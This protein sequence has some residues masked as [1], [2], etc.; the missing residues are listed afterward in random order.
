MKRKSHNT[1]ALRRVAPRA[2]WRGLWRISRVPLAVCTLAF[3]VYSRSFLNGFVRDDHLQ[4]VSNPQVQSWDRLPEILTSH[5][6][7]HAGTR[8]VLFYRPLFSLWMLIIHTLGGLS[9]WFWHLSSAALHVACT[10]L[11]YRLAKQLIGSNLGSVAAAA[12]FAVHPIHVDAVG[13]VS[14]SNELLFTL[15]MLAALLVLMAPRAK[16]AGWPV[17]VSALL[18]FAGLFAKET[19]VAMIVLLVVAAR[20]RLKDRHREIELWAMAVGPYLLAAGTWL[21]IR[22]LVL[23]GAGIEN[24]EHT[25]REVCFSAPSILLFYL[26]KLAVPLKLSGGYVNPIYASP[27]SQFLLPLAVG[28]VILLLATWL[29]VRHNWLIGFSAALILLP[30][31]PALV[32]I[33]LYPQGDMT[34]DRYLYLPSVGFCL[35]AGL[36]VGWLW[37]KSRAMAVATGGVAA[38]LLITFCV[39]T[40]AQQRFYH[41]DIA[42]LQREI[43]VN[44]RNAYAYALLGNVEMDDVRTDVALEHYRIAARLAPDDPKIN[45][46]LARGLFAKRQYSEAEEV[47]SRLAARK[48]FDTNRQNA[49][50]LSLANVEISLG[51]MDAAGSLLQQVERSDSHFPELHWALGVLYQKEGR[52]PEAQKEYEEEY[53]STGDEAARQQSI[54]LSKQILSRGSTGGTQF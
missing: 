23:H 41:D 31:L 12:I 29:T 21:T 25:W 17:V 50:L 47:L 16:A 40:F 51:K 8:E 22:W 13:W 14:A 18:F 42:F 11:V 9:P 3:L 38:A 49:I 4:I 37:M 35:L 33:R 7:S 30:L 52:V 36:F 1:G 15:L 44:P 43:D 32:A 19:G 26:G 54:V 53:Q 24:G 39:L 34:H 6:W 20:I 2:D 27:A 46:F 10:Y 48:D 5:L 45:L 28:L